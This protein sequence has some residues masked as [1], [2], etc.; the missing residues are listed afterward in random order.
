ML[1]FSIIG[2]LD[3]CSRLIYGY[4]AD[5]KILKVRLIELR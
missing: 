3:F 2:A 4:V 5:L 1:Y